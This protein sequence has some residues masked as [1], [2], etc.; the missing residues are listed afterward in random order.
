MFFSTTST[1]IGRFNYGGSLGRANSVANGFGHLGDMY[2]SEPR[3]GD[4]GI[5]LGTDVFGQTN[6]EFQTASAVAAP[7]DVAATEARLLREHKGRLEVR[8]QQLEDHN[9]QLE[10]Q[11][12]RLRQYLVGAPVG[13]TPSGPLGPGGNSK[14]SAELLLDPNILRQVGSSHGSSN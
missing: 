4:P 14:V 5:V 13:T 11:L 12:Q 3:V 1:V 8:M 2:G 9:R 10:Q 6:A 7:G